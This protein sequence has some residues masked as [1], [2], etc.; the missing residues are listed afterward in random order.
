MK[1]QV[2]AI[3]PGSFD[4]PTNGH[5]DL[6]ERGAKIFDVLIVAVLRNS[7]K[8]PLFSTEERLSMLRETT[9]KWSNVRVDSFEGL[10]VDYAITERSQGR[11]ERN[12]RRQRL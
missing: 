9:K 4:P 10:L 7:A 8:A 11:S 2:I 5:L 12:P 1:K 3:Y 6:I